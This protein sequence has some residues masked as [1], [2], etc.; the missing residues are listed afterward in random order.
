MRIKLASI[1]ALLGAF[2]CTS[3]TVS[4]ADSETWTQKKAPLTTR[5]AKDVNQDNV[6]P[7]YPRPQMVR[8]K[9]MNLNGLWDYAI[10]S[11]DLETPQSYQGKILVPFAAESAISGVMQSVNDQ[12]QIWYKRTFSIPEEWKN[13]NLILHFGASDWETTVFVNNKKVGTHKG[14]YTAFEMDITNAQQV[15]DVIKVGDYDAVVHCAAWTAVDKAEEP[16]LLDKVRAVNAT[17]TQNIVTVCKELD[18]PVMY[19]STDYVFDGQG[20]TPW[21]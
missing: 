21:N 17:G 6:H 14:G 8:D 19:F 13:K 11:R 16:E 18:I 9:W 2:Y 5:W 20:T 7:E 10:V 1:I 4:Y 3:G 12:Q 15:N